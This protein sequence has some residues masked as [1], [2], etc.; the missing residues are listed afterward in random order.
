MSY[1]TE[2]IAHAE[3]RLRRGALI[4]A[5]VL[6]VLVLTIVSTWP[7]F[8]DSG[9]GDFTED[10]PDSMLRA[11]GIADLS[12]P[13]GFL[14]SNLFS[15]LLPLLMICVA[16]AWTNGLTAA[17]EESGRLEHELTLPVTRTGVFL[18]RFA[19]VGSLH[20]GLGI[21]V[22]VFLTSSMPALELDASYG[23]VTLATLAV[24]LLGLLHSAVLYCAAGLG[25]S[26]GLALGVSAG[27][28]GFGYVGNSLFPLSSA[29]EPLQVLSPWYWLIGDGPVQNGLNVG[30]VTAT[31]VI[32]AALVAVGTVAINRRD[33]HSA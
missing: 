19:T 14:D 25:A 8:R 16:I 2:V 30:G 32:G 5:A 3:K 24:V 21:V 31:V 20:I 22:L 1:G 18:R 23:K 4:W 13:A 27:V 28:A 15:L 33:I 7:G 29:L 11:F 17:D 26:P 10:L 9:S 12:D 6:A